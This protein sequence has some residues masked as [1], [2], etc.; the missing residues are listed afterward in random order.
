MDTKRILF[1]GGGGIGERHI[2]CFLKT[3]N[4][5]AS[6]CDVDESRIHQL[7]DQYPLKA[8]FT[9]FADVPLTDFDGVVIAVPA[10]LHIPVAVQCARAGLPFLVEKPL[11]VNLDGVNEL[12]ELIAEKNL[13]AAVGFVRRSETSH[14]KLRELALSGLI[15]KLM[16]GRFN[17]SQEYPKY[18]PDYCDIYYAHP[19]TGGGCIL[20]AASHGVN[21]T[22]WIFGE[23]QEVVALY[24]RLVLTGV[25]CEDSVIIMQRFRKNS[26]LVEIFINQFQK[27]NTCEIEIIGTAGNVRYEFS[28]GQTLITHCTDDSN[29]WQELYTGSYTADE[30]FVM[31]AEDVLAGMAGNAEPP[32]SVAQAAANLGVLLAAKQSQRQGRIISVK[33]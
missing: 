32:T 20:D 30:P 2:R 6:L 10:H 23:V 18:R 16:M 29:Q 27:P 8:T 31:Q 7:A 33:E 9:D 3:G 1:V 28:C 24:D 12:V 17:L 5:E 19:E 26:A 14:K 13:Y 21:L 15:G 22:E 25:E 4:V 11:S